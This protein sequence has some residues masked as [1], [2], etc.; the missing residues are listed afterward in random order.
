MKIIN[1]KTKYLSKDLILQCFEHGKI[2]YIDKVVTGN[3]FTTGFGNISP[4]DGLVNVLVAPNQSI[5]KDKQEDHKKGEFAK[6]LRCAFVYEGSP[7]HASISSL[8]LIVIVADSFNNNI[9]HIKNNVDKLMVDEFHS[10]IIQSSFRKQLKKLQGILKNDFKDSSVVFVT[11]SPLLDWK[12]DIKINNS[13]M[14]ERDLH[15][16]DNLTKSINRC[17]HN[18]TMEKKT[19]VFSNSASLIIRILKAANVT[20]FKLIGGEKMTQGLLSRGLWNLDD[21]SNL[22]ICS[23]AGFEGWSDHSKD[24]SC[25]IFMNPKSKHESYLGCN[26]YQAIG[27]LRQGYEYAELCCIDSEPSGFN[28][29]QIID[30]LDGKL[31]A[32]INA[33]DSVEKKDAK[34]YEFYYSKT[35][36]M[37]DAKPLK[38]FVVFGWDDHRMT[39]EIYNQGILTHNERKRIKPNMNIYREYFKDRLVSFIELDEE[40]DVKKAGVSNNKK[41]RPT[42]IATNLESND[43]IDTVDNYFFQNIP[44]KNEEKKEDYAKN[45]AKYYIEEIN[46]KRECLGMLGESLPPK[47]DKLLEYFE[48]HKGYYRELLTLVKE[49][50]GNRVDENGV[51]WSYRKKRDYISNWKIETFPN[52]LLAA[53]GMILGNVQHNW[54][55]SRDYNVFTTIGMNEIVYIADKLNLK[56]MEVDIKNCFPRILY[57]VNGKELPIDF[58]GANDAGRSSRKVKAN[59]VINSFRYDS[60]SKTPKRQ[61][62]SRQRKRIIDSGYDPIVTDYL[63][64]MFF[65]SEFKADVFNFLAFHEAQV[66]RMAIDIMQKRDRESVFFRRHDSFMVFE[67]LGHKVLDKFEYKSTAGWFARQN[68]DKIVNQLTLSF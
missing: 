63:M 46:A 24:G 20:T 17:V 22:V 9:K 34:G 52:T 59:V 25:F 67:E 43:I 7:L 58:Y 16:T 14:Y 39:I 5:V 12:M 50:I 11:A 36:H 57:A 42:F 8:D 35:Q 18:I 2:N 49:K 21:D 54:V 40:R 38:D 4:N 19:I 47:F 23:S 13:E 28:R 1:N 33:D 30:D 61:Q 37:V 15:I 41:L 60:K 45:I 29:I 51:P 44:F 31:E 27:R 64:K 3:G 10:V 48:V 68:N 65:D 56:V 53:T 62:E 55:A 6:D 32:F 26:I 66:I